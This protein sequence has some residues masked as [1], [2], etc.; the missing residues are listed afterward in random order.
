MQP[1][2]A[3][4]GLLRF[5]GY[6]GHP[7]ARRRLRRILAALWRLP[8]LSVAHEPAKHAFR[9]VLRMLLDPSRRFGVAQAGGY[10][11]YSGG[12]LHIRVARFSYGL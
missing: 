10:I 4:G 11:P 8:L 2:A 9:I 5:R 3:L 12:I 1:R 7:V 6:I